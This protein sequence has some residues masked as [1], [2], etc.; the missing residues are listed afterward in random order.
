MRHLRSAT[1][2]SLAAE[3]PGLP[4]AVARRVLGRVVFED[5]D[6]LDGVRGLGTVARRAILEP[7]A[8]TGSK[9]PTGVAA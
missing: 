2:E 1:P 3:V 6:N 8:S 7:T 5:R 9:W 4:L